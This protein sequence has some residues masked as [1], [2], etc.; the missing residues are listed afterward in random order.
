MCLWCMQVKELV[1]GQWVR[2]RE[3]RELRVS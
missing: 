3:P 2:F 1:R